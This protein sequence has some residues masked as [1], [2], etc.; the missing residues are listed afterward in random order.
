MTPWADTQYMPRYPD[1]Q[2]P[3]WLWWLLLALAIGNVLSLTALL[4]R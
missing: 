3:T 2:L 1:P 4:S